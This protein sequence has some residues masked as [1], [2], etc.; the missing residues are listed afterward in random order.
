MQKKR[1]IETAENTPPNRVLTKYQTQTVLG[2]PVT[3]HIWSSN[4]EK[5]PGRASAPVV[6][7]FLLIIPGHKL[8]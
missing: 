8:T 4:W 2:S 5:V 3:Q 1:K 7:S 6:S